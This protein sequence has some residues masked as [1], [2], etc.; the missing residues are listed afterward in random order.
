[1]K[2]IYDIPDFDVSEFLEFKVISNSSVNIPN[3]SVSEYREYS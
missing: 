1:M 2:K 3:L